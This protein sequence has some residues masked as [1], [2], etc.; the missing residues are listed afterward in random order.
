MNGACGKAG[1]ACCTGDVGCTQPLTDCR[2]NMCQACGGSG[3]ACC[4]NDVCA[5]G[6]CANGH[7][8]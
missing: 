1:Q 5:N 8:P 3:Q 6:A 4:Q 7:C 2:N